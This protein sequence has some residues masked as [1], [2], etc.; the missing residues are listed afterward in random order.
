MLQQLNKVKNGNFVPRIVHYILKTLI[1]CQ[2]IQA[3]FGG[4]ERK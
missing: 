2:R 4:E 1:D 3:M